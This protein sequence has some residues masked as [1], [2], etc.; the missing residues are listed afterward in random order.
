MQYRTLGHTGE[1]VSCI[2][3][4]TLH[5]PEQEEDLNVMKHCFALGIEAGINLIDTSANYFAGRSDRFTA[6]VL[7]EHKHKHILVAAKCFFPVEG[8]NDSAGLG[9]KAIRNTVE[10]SLRDLQVETIDI[11]QCHRWDANTTVQ[12]TATTMNALIREGKIRHWGL[13][14][15]R[16]SQLVEVH[17]TCRREG[18]MAPVS[19]QH[20]YNMFNRT[21]EAEILETS[22]WLGLSTLAYSPMAQGVLSGKYSNTVAVGG[23]RAGREDKRKTMWD[24]SE[25]KIEKAVK[26][27]ALAAEYQVT[28]PALALAWCLRK[29]QVSS[30]ISGISNELQLQQNL[31]A[32]ELEITE[33]MEQKIAA[34]LCNEP[35]NQYLN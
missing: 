4:G 12:E 35:Y 5:L 7:K 14:A 25:T 18:L 19:H 9:E 13:G 32:A 27:A 26:L 34:I 8:V 15:A 3:L 24:F 28:M 20:V 21:V 1:T 33:E 23:S 6:A 16:V 2:S 22:Q 29:P 10:Q 31:Q 11:L 17:E 30:V